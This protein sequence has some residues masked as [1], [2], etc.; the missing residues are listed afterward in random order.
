[1]VTFT[2]TPEGAAFCAADRIVAPGGRVSAIGIM[3][4]LATTSRRVGR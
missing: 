2:G 1:M 4:P 3:A